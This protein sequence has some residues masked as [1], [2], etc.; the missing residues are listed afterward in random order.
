MNTLA[1]TP[2]TDGI[3]AL[4][5]VIMPVYNAEQTL[6]R[7]AESVLAQTFGRV[8][9]ILIDDGSR[10]GS[11]AL[12]A[13]LAARDDRVVAL[14]QANAGVAAA[15]NAGLRAVRGTHVA[16]LDSDDWWEPR[17]LEL[18]LARMRET[19]AQVCYASYQRVAE[20]GRLLSKVSPPL[21]VDYRRMLGSNHIGNLTGIYDRRLGE[22]AFQRMGHED[23]VF[24]LE[25]VRRAGHA[26]RV[27]QDEPLAYY[28]VRN[29][30]VSANKLR[31]AGWQ[32]RIYRQ[33]EGLSA[34]RAAWYML[35]YIRHALWKRKPM[36]T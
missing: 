23:Y 24:W 21:S 13:E 10:D 5:S 16:F 15:R 2:S 12:I 11:A 1:A 35:H 9:L 36:A 6:R 14:R 31:A 26:V 30:S 7:S 28:L 4:V 19:G 33:V 27:E 3:D 17:K 32:W 25:R 8:E 34:P 18:Q 29:G 22:A 20:D